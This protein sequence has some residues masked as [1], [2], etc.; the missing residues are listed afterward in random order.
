MTLQS[1]LFTGDESSLSAT[2]AGGPTPRSVTPSITTTPAKTE[3]ESDDGPTSL[4]SVSVSQTPT[5]PSSP[6]GSRSVSGTPSRSS[7]RA[8]PATPN[9][10]K[11]SKGHA[12]ST[13][14]QHKKHSLTSSLTNMM[15]SLDFRS[16]TGA[17]DYDDSQS[18]RSD[19]SSDSENF[20]IISQAEESAMRDRE[21]VD[22]ALF[23]I[24]PAAA[25]PPAK[26]PS[27]VEVAMEV[28]EDSICSARS[29]GSRVSSARATPQ[30]NLSAEGQN[31][32]RTVTPSADQRRPS[33]HHDEREGMVKIPSLVSLML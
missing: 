16:P 22:A 25:A 4:T 29:S 27:P 7:S 8:A 21:S 3:V 28:T 19:G 5:I 1:D 24:H 18:I 9:S 6:C 30:P 11:V 10:L 32:S 13:P 33:N 23:N 15:A 17:S 2:P 31:L 26:A 14:G 12:T 20:V